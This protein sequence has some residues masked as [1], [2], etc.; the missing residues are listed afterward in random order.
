MKGEVLHHEITS[1]NYFMN[2]DELLCN[3]SVAN[4]LFPGHRHVTYVVPVFIDVSASLFAV[5][6]CQQLHRRYSRKFSDCLSLVTGTPLILN[7]L[8]SAV[9]KVLDHS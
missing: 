1:S 3:L 7:I 8:F 5:V 9:P 6:T 2:G 4:V